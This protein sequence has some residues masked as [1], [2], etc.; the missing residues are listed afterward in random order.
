[1]QSNNK[2]NEHSSA[3]SKNAKPEDSGTVF[4]P[5]EVRVIVKEFLKAYIGGKI[6]IKFQDVE[7]IMQRTKLEKQP[8]DFRHASE[9]EVE[10]KI[11]FANLIEI[12]MGSKT[13]S[14]EEKQDAINAMINFILVSRS[15]ERMQ[16]EFLTFDA[17]KMIGE[18]R[19]DLD[20]TN[21]VVAEIMVFLR[22]RT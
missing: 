2:Q 9:R 6:V 19:K 8:L 16:G 4:S 12:C 10:D 1:M 14:K 20:E 18:L 13:A 22:S 21:R 5:E 17:E 11:N 3:E 7:E 15:S